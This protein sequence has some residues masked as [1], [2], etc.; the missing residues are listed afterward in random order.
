MTA[1]EKALRLISEF[2]VNINY[3]ESF[4]DYFAQ[5]SAIKVADEIIN[6]LEKVCNGLRSITTET[7]TPE[8]RLKYWQDVK[9]ELELL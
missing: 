4:E 3:E 5:K 9:K 8:E 7:P 1:K 6:V 2:R